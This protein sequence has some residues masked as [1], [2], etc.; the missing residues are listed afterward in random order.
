MSI[1]SQALI[2]VF[3]IL[4]SLTLTR[5]SIG[6][7]SLAGNQVSRAA[8]TTVTPAAN[9]LSY[10]RASLLQNAQVPP[11]PVRNWDVLDP[12]VTAKAVL[13]QSLDDYYPFFNY[14][15]YVSW[16]AASLTKLLTAV[17]VLEDIGQNKKISV[18]AAAAAADGSSAGLRSGEVYTA[19]DLLKIMLLASANDAAAAFEE[20][21]GAENFLSLTNEKMRDLGMNQTVILDSSGLNDANVSSASDLMRLTRYIV[22]NHP[23]IFTWTRLT[24]FLAQPINDVRTQSLQN[25]DRLVEEPDF[26]GGKTGTSEAAGQNLLAIFNHNNLRIA[27]IILGSTDRYADMSHLLNW[28][29]KAYTY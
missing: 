19:Q 27:I 24:S 2:L 26:L 22:E 23:E 15:T 25:I 6:P 17:V 8:K 11:G 20:Y 12:K 28:L 14:N 16:P 4:V 9:D 18:S 7:S 21:L 5:I 10:E 1:R 3:L 13:I 29:D